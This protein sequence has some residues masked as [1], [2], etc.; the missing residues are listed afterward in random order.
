MP[1]TCCGVCRDAVA[2]DSPSWP[3]SLRPKHSSAVDVSTTHVKSLPAATTSADDVNVTDTGVDDS[4]STAGSLPNC[5]D[6]LEPKHHAR[7]PTTTHECVVPAAA[8][9]DE[10]PPNAVMRPGVRLSEVEEVPRRPLLYAPQHHVSPVVLVAHACNAPRSSDA[11]T[12]DDGIDVTA[13]GVACATA[14]CVP[15]PSWP[16]LF[17]PQHITALVVSTAQV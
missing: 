12:N 17:R 8:D 15:L 1:D 5:P 4:E 9:V 10:P 3:L 14:S 16:R 2:I 13:D 11:T 6:E 7:V